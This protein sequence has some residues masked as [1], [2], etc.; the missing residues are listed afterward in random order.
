MDAVARDQDVRS[1]A[2]AVLKGESHF[3]VLLRN[4]L[5]LLSEVNALRRYR[6]Q[7]PAMQVAAMHDDMRLAEAFFVLVAENHLVRDLA[8]VPV[9]ALILLRVKALVGDF[10]VEAKTGEDVHG[11]GTDLDAGADTCKGRRLLEHLHVHTAAR[12]TSRYSEPA[13]SCTDYTDFQRTRFHL[14]RL[15]TNSN[16]AS[17]APS[18]LFDRHAG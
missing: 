8:R 14:P 5:E 6:T 10:L 4:V 3:A 11:V 9:P 1:L 7:Q 17:P 18:L 15:I 12:E 13:H 2:A 16:G